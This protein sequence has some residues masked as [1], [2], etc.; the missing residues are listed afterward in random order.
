MSVGV[1]GF[2]LLFISKDLPPKTATENSAMSIVWRNKPTCIA[3]KSNHDSHGYRNSRN[4]ATFKL[5]MMV[6]WVDYSISYRI[7]LKK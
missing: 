3:E 5:L 1:S 2:S 7:K 4:S 6:I